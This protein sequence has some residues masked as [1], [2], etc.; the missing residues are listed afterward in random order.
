MRIAHVFQD[1]RRTRLYITIYYI[2][3]NTDTAVYQYNF[4]EKQYW[5]GKEFTMIEWL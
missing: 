4:P 1:L 2:H 5:M 3:Y